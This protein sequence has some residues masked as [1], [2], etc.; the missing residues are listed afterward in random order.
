MS[1][2]VH[3][4]LIAR[5]QGLCDVFAALEDPTRL[6]LV[7]KLCDAQSHSISRL[8][9]EAV[10]TRQAV[11]KHLRVLENAGI[12]HCVHIGRESRFALDPEPIDDLRTYLHNISEQW[13]HAL[14]RLKKFV[15]D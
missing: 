8:A 14:V 1:S 9:E 3:N 11:T 10:L 6:F 7:A 4:K 12:V 13:D 2:G 15:E 5:Q